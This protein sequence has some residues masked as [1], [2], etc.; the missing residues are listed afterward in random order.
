MRVIVQ[1]VRSAR[2]DIDG[3]TVGRIG[4]GLVALVGF[5]HGDTA[6]PVAKVASKLVGMRLFA[7]ASG[8][9]NLSLE[10]VG[11]GILAISQFTLYADIRKGRR[12]SFTGALEPAEAER[13]YGLFVEELRRMHRVG[14]VE[15][16]VFGAMMD[17]H[18]VNA[19]PVT[20][21]IDSDDLAIP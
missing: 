18:L 2:V 21:L 6:R 13:L 4:Q 3:A 9:P 5:R 16:G 19:G 12:P 8:K 1:R 17:V 7:D 15:T 20:I 11:G 10:D 14:P